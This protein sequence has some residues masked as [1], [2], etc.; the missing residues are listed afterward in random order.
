M[1]T[2]QDF[3]QKLNDAIIQADVIKIFDN[4]LTIA[5][6]EGASDIHIEPFENYSRIRIR[7]DGDLI[8]LVQYPNNIHESIISKF[9]IESGQMRPDEKRLPQDAR[10]S[11]VTLTN[12]EIDLRANTLPTVW[13][14]K[15][16]MRIVDKSKKIP[17]INELG[18]EGI[19]AELLYKN[20]AYPN[21]IILNTGPTGSGKTAT[22][23]A[24][25]DF[26][27][28]VDVNIIT[29]EDPVEVKLF[30]LNQSQIRTDIG[31]TFASGLRAALRQDPDIIMV[32]EIRDKETLDMAMDAAMTGH[33]V[34][35]TIHTNS[36]VETITRVFNL[37]AKAFMLAGTFNGVIAQRLSKKI[38]SHCAVDINIKDKPA[39]QFAKQAFA[40]MDR[41]ML[42]D[43]IVRRGISSEQWT[44]FINDGITSYG[45]GKDPQ[46][47]ETCSVCG[48]SG[49]KGRIGI[50]EFMDYNEEV[51]KMLLDGKSAFDIEKYALQYGMIN[52]ERDGIFKVIK[53]QI[54]IDDVY[55][56]VKHH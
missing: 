21:G 30:G 5:V 6:E 24:C 19:N 22:L 31:F 23:Y 33:L 48:G 8:E 20:L 26:I 32:G 16:V 56:I 25:L 51:K 45:S 13:G 1:L 47:G 35:S 34:L 7:I 43:E 18:L 39:F 12:K 40:T 46:S 3:K 36:S 49:Y 41:K 52:L 11:T 38:C 9:K 55:K 54:F 28:K 37:G 29:Y 27:N 42:K 53:G 10:V 50:F 17:L 4:L 44:K 2:V 14:E 15:L